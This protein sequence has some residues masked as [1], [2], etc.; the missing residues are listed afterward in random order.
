MGGPCILVVD[1]ELSFRLF[2]KTLFET[3]G[4]TV[5]AARNGKEGLEKARTKRPAC[6]VLD[7]MMPER[8]GLEMYRGL[9]STP[10]LRNIP[11]VMLS[12]VAAKGFAHALK[13]IGLSAGE[14]PSPEAYVEK[15]PRP[16]P[17]LEIVR[18]LIEQ[19]PS[20]QDS[21]TG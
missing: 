4:F 2:L 11:V 1:D 9:K 14:L 5:V 21:K 13:M 17:L 6:I 10:E 20:S 12:A 7:V 15:P 8:G 19:P 3:G 18:G 16:G